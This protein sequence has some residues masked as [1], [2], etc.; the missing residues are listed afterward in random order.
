MIGGLRRQV[1]GT[2][3]FG[4]CSFSLIPEQAIQAEPKSDIRSSSS[5]RI[6]CAVRDGKP[7]TMAR[8]PEKT[9]SLIQWVTSF[10]GVTPKRR[11]E[12][13]SSNFQTYVIDGGRDYIAIATVNR[14]PV[15]CAAKNPYSD[16]KTLFSLRT[17]QETERMKKVLQNPQYIQSPL[18]HSSEQQVYFNLN[19][20]LKNQ[21]TDDSNFPVKN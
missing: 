9:F 11:C 4:L 2:L 10:G 16:C 19:S 13:A 7:A 12:I 1:L 21:V 14:M 3:L 15:L 20:Y 8:T 6:Y 5:I 18:S 17:P